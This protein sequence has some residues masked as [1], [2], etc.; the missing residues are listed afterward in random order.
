VPQAA[1]VLDS[2]MAVPGAPDD[3]SVIS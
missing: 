1:I 2:S 3:A